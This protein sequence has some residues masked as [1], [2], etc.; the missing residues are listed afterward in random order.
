MVDNED[1]EIE[2]GDDDS[3]YFGKCS[4][5]CN[6]FGFPKLYTYSKPK[7]ILIIGLFIGLALFGCYLMVCG[8]SSMIKPPQ[9]IA[10]GTI[11][12]NY[13][14]S[15]EDVFYEFDKRNELVVFNDQPWDA[16]WVWI[17]TPDEYQLWRNGQLSDGKI[18]EFNSDG[19]FPA[20][21]IKY[22]VVMKY[23]GQSESI[24]YIMYGGKYQIMTVI[25]N[26]T[27][28][29]KFFKMYEAKIEGN[30]T[31]QK[32][33]CVDTISQP[34]SKPVIAVDKFVIPIYR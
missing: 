18:H 4:D 13:S 26:K 11:A 21:S 12:G 8:I 3:E 29:D 31:N 9:L 15:Y 20:N 32:F 22:N 23:Y 28:G 16:G 34:A 17:G 33:S 1:I 14:L 5:D 24:G 2:D 10:N 25:S 30:V 6:K 19:I 7:Q 27:S